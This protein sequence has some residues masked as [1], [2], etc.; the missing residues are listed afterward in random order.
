M[1]SILWGGKV[2]VLVFEKVMYFNIRQQH[3]KMRKK[4][5]GK[6]TFKSL[7]SVRCFFFNTFLIL[8]KAAFI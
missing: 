2:F 6:K 3:N 4:M 8:I 7:G 1:E 5:K